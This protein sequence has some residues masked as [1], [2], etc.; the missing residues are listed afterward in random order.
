MHRVRQSD[1]DVWR[2]SLHRAR[3]HECVF[4]NTVREMGAGAGCD[5]PWRLGYEK[6]EMATYAKRSGAAQH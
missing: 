6:S 1:G 5:W 4:T 2:R 3:N